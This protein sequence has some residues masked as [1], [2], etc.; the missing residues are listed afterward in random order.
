MYLIDSWY[1]RLLNM[2]V[3]SEGH[4]A[5]VANFKGELLLCFVLLPQHS[6]EEDL[7]LVG[8]AVAGGRVA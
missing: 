2:C 7:W 6:A 1:R 5:D 3:L 8:Q 4:L